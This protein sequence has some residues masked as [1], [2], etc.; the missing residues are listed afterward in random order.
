MGPEES[1]RRSA[2]RRR[3]G[4]ALH[5]DALDMTRRLDDATAQAGGRNANGREQNGA[6]K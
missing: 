6:R 2:R 1:P 5:F 3:L 4:N